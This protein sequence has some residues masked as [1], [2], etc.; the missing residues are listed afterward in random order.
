M[1]ALRLV[2]SALVLLV[3]GGAI[4]QISPGEQKDVMADQFTELALRTTLDG[5]ANVARLITN[6]TPFGKGIFKPLFLRMT[7]DE[8]GQLGAFL[9]R[10]SESDVKQLAERLNT[11]G[12]K[13]LG[14][15]WWE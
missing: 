10:A 8:L 11:A 13:D 4:Q 5:R 14:P 3:I 7:L 9:N 15:R 12:S 1:K 6:L 2:A